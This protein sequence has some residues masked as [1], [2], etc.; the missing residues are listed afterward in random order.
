MKKNILES[1]EQMYVL[2]D[3]M[4]DYGVELTKDEKSK[5][6]EAAKAFVKANKKILLK[7]YPEQRKQSVVYWNL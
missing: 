1:L 6:Q 2:E 7:K 3:H 4:A 5:I